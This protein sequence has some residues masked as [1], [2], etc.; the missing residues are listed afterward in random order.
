[1]LAWMEPAWDSNWR[2][3]PGQQPRFMPADNDCK[4]RSFFLR[5]V[6]TRVFFLRSAWRIFGLRSARA[7]QNSDSDQDDDTDGDP[8]LRNS[9]QIGGDGET[10]DQYNE[11][12]QVGTE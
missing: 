4:Y 8:Q 9:N 12:D 6:I 3:L 10:D 7:A 2:V 11:S 1:M 5:P